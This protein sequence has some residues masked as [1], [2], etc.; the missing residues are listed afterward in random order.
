[1]LIFT[2]WCHAVAL[3]PLCPSKVTDLL[4]LLNLHDTVS[5]SQCPRD[6][7][8]LMPNFFYSGS[9][10]CCTFFDCDFS[11]MYAAVDKLSTNILYHAQRLLLLSFLLLVGFSALNFLLCALTPLVAHM[12][13]IVLPGSAKTLYTSS[14]SVVLQLSFYHLLVA[15][16]L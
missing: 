10:T 5:A 1:M 4:K 6:C 7:G 15:E 13:G 2:V 8:F 9:F 11:F 14:I 16:C 12:K 3:C